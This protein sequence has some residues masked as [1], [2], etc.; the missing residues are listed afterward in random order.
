MVFQ[1]PSL[2]QLHRECMLRLAA[3]T[4]NLR[5]IAIGAPFAHELIELAESDLHSALDSVRKAEEL[6]DAI[7]RSISTGLTPAR[8]DS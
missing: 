5:M 2:E 7:S 6:R 8:G 1:P 3:A 4:G